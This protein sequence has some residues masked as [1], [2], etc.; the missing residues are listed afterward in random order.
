MIKSNVTEELREKCE[1]IIKDEHKRLIMI[2]LLSTIASYMES[3][4]ESA[5]EIFYLTGVLFFIKDQAVGLC[6]QR[7]QNFTKSLSTPMCT[8]SINNY[9]RCLHYGHSQKPIFD[10]VYKYYYTHVLKVQPNINFNVK[11]MTFRVYRDVSLSS[12]QIYQPLNI[13]QQISPPQKF[14][15]FLSSSYPWHLY[16]V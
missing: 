16:F 6:R 9:F 3:H 7:F 2:E 1:S 10:L 5:Q 12:P 8:T 11:Q 4:A 13:K 14:D 15:T